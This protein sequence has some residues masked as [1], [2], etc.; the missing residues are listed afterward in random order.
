MLDMT[1][2]HHFTSQHVLSISDEPLVVSG[3]GD[4]LFVATACCR[5]NHYIVLKNESEQCKFFGSFPSVAAVNQMV[6][7]EKGR[8]I[9]MTLF[10]FRL[11]VVYKCYNNCSFLPSFSLTGCA[12][13]VDV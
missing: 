4:D 13:S 3:A 11:G 1:P 8:Y 10:H 2:C 9:L 6:Y 5:I 12:V 7:S